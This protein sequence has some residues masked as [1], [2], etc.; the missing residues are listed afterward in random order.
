[1]T[2]T[3]LVAPIYHASGLDSQH[4]ICAAFTGKGTSSEKNHNFS[5][6]PTGG[7]GQSGYFRRNLEYLAGQLAFDCGRLTWP[8]G[9]WPHSGQAIIAENFEWV[10]NKR[11]GGIMPVE[12]QNE[13]TAVTYD[14]IV[15]RSP[16]FVLGVQGADCQS[17]FLYEP[18]AQVIGLAHAGWK[19][20]GRE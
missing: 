8:N 16:R 4:R 5:F 15:T 12:P 18:E 10:A 1:M 3:S 6:R 9:G 13:P 17:I 19:P 7:D 20:L 11:T 2:M 14:G